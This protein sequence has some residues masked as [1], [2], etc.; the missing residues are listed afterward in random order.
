MEHQLAR[1]GQKRISGT[2]HGV[3]VRAR[4][5][6]CIG[7]FFEKPGAMSLANGYRSSCE[8]QQVKDLMNVIHVKEPSRG[9]SSK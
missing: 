4:G 1:S 8:L 2:T 5:A 3:R 9:R 7:D 6:M